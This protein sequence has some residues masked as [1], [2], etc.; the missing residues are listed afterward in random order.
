MPKPPGA[1]GGGGP[2]SSNFDQS[3][4]G[5]PPGPLTAGKDEWIDLGAIPNGQAV[6]FGLG[7]FTSPDKS[8]TF[9]IRGNILGQGSG[10]DGNTELLAA[11]TATPRKGTVSKDMYRKGR[12]HTVTVIGTGTEHYW[13]RLKSKQQTAGSYLYE[14][15]YTLE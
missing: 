7:L 10:T 13:L 6:W 8:I 9:E 5:P 2:G 15:T 3:I 4:F 11:A 14:I 12:L 1:G